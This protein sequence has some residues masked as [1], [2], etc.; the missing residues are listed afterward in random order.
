M[1]NLYGI[2]WSGYGL[3][4]FF[5]SVDAVEGTADRD[6]QRF[7]K[8]LIEPVGVLRGLLEQVS[9]LLWVIDPPAAFG[10][11][12][13]NQ[14][15]HGRIHNVFRREVI[16]QD[17]FGCGA[18]FVREGMLL[19]VQQGKLAE[20]EENVVQHISLLPGDAFRDMEP[21]PGKPLEGKVLGA[22]PGFGMD[23]FDPCKISDDKGINA[24]I[25][26]KGVKGLLVLLD[27][28]GV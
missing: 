7:V 26:V 16:R 18:I 9:G 2:S 27:L 19:L 13:S 24:I 8:A 6:R 21:V 14:F 12:E 25:L 15:I 11:D 28:I 10:A 1:E 4:L 22:P 17:G 20:L 23:A 3:K 5:K